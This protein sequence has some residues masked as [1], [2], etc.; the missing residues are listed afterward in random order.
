MCV[1]LATLLMSTCG[2]GQHHSDSPSPPATTPVPVPASASE[3]IAG[4]NGYLQELVVSSAD[5]LE[6]M[7]TSM[8]TAPTDDS[9]EPLKVD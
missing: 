9:S 1:A 4:F 8:V 3:S 6:P 5:T 2:G 7:D